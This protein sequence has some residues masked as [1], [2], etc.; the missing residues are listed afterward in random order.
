MWILFAIGASVFWGLTYVFNEQ[1]YKKISVLTSL[2]LASLVI[3]II[4]L[5]LSYFSNNLKPDLI[6]I[7][8][9]KKLLLFVVL[10]IIAL[11]IA[12]LFIGFSI[13]AKNATLSGLI[14]I[15]YP[16][17]IALFSYILFKNTQLTTSVLIG[18][19]L[20]FAGIFII[21]SFNK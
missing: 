2:A 10:G 14:E 12:E 7:A 8:S 19:I 11:L 4:T 3:F 17:F 13:T 1:V 18:G 20:I 5:A 15:S 16:I 6:S 9:S 21:Y